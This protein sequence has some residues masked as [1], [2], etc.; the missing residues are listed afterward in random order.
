MGRTAGQP[1]EITSTKDSLTTQLG[2]RFEV[3]EIDLNSSALC[4]L[5]SSA[6]SPPPTPVLHAWVAQGGSLTVAEKPTI[7]DWVAESAPP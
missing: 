3:V 1:L 4:C 2:T 5:S 7:I 6:G